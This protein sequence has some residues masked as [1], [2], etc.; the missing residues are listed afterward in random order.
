MAQI[1]GLGNPYIYLNYAAVWQDRIDGY[2][3]TMG[4]ELQNV[5]EMYDST[6]VF[7]K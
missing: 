4:K 2:G 6:G 5:S 3:V 7:Q 1:V